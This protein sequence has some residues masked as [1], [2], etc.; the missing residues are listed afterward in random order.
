MSTCVQWCRELAQA[1]SL[2]MILRMKYRIAVATSWVRGDVYFWGSLS[3]RALLA[4]API[5]GM[6]VGDA[7]V[8]DGRETSHKVIGQRERLR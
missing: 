2:D 8:E 7:H 4:L 5:T 1:F 6:D 3:A